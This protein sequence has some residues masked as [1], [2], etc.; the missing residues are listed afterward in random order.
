MKFMYWT[1]AWGAIILAICTGF[2]N[3]QGPGEIARDQTDTIYTIEVEGRGGV[4]TYYAK[5]LPEI[6]GDGHVCTFINKETGRKMTILTC[7]K[8]VVITPQ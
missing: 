8:T 7:P 6:T 2:S 5:G 1:I 4:K 3:P